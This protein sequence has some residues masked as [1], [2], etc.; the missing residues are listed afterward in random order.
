MGTDFFRN[1]I[2]AWLKS[3]CQMGLRV[4]TKRAVDIVP[5]YYPNELINSLKNLKAQH[6]MLDLVFVILDSPNSDFYGD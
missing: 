4:E 3:A 1:F 2:V 6:A 5:V